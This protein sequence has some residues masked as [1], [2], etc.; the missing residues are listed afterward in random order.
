V[1]RDGGLESGAVRHFGDVNCASIEGLLRDLSSF[2]CH[3]TAT[4]APRTDEI[5]WRLLRALRR[6]RSRQN[7]FRVQPESLERS[8]LAV[9]AGVAR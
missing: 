3:A 8:F 5:H 7:D 4:L 6:K 2:G 1:L 9:V